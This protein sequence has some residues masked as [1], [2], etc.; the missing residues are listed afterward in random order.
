MQI[1]T[2]PL[3]DKGSVALSEAKGVFSLAFQEVLLDGGLS[4][5]GTVAGTLPVL[6]EKAAGFTQST[7]VKYILAE[8]GKLTAA[9]PE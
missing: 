6:L 7:M 4:L 9:L 8:L 3:G 2:I 1:I 5:T